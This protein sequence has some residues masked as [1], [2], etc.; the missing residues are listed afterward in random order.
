MNET[1]MANILNYD[2]FSKSI[3]AIFLNDHIGVPKVVNI[4]GVL[5][6]TIKL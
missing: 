1:M 6:M 4:E 5:I 3:Y 2:Q